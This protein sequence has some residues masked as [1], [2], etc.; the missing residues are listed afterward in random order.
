MFLTCVYELVWAVFIWNSKQT[1]RWL[2]AI[3]NAIKTMWT[4]SWSSR[5]LAQDDETS[6]AL[7]WSAASPSPT[8]STLLLPLGLSGKRWSHFT[9]SIPWITHHIIGAYGFYIALMNT[10]GVLLHCKKKKKFSSGVTEFYWDEDC[11][12]LGYL[13]IKN[14][15]SFRLA[16]FSILK[17]I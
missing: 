5:G 6:S 14:M 17:E 4:V 12:S 13:T 15:T 3:V 9:S 8:S 11:L 1:H 7:L 16:D 10:I 2:P